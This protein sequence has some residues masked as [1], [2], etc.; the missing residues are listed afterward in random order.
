L[1][2]IASVYG[3]CHTNPT[4]GGVV[5][6][7]SSLLGFRTLNSRGSLT[8]SLETA[9]S[10]PSTDKVNQETDI[11]LSELNVFRTGNSAPLKRFLGPLP[12]DKGTVILRTMVSD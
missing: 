9:V 6:L 8:A 4:G 11:C 12:G 5:L 3:S 10:A 2:S 7:S 1:R